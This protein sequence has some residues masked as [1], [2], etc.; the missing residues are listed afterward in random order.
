MA[1][2]P[3]NPRT[4][5]ILA[6]IFPGLGHL[7]VGRFFL[8]LIFLAMI[9][10]FTI[11]YSVIFSSNLTGKGPHNYLVLLF[12]PC[13]L[14]SQ[15]IDASWLAKGRNRAVAVNERRSRRRK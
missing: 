13:A 11:Y 2:A 14:I 8:F 12:F 15:A 6:L 4:A 9:N 3:K 1:K 10:P 5:F 7:Y